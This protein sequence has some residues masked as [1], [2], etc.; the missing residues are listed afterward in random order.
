MRRSPHLCAHHTRPPPVGKGP[1]HTTPPNTHMCSPHGPH[2]LTHRAGITG[3]CSLGWQKQWVSS[4]CEPAPPGTLGDV[5][6][7]VVVMT[8]GVTASS[9]WGPWILLSAPQ[10]PGQPPQRMTCPSVTSAEGGTCW[11]DPRGRG[12]LSVFPPTARCP[13]RNHLSPCS[14]C[15]RV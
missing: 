5:W 1:A 9:G 2:L 13:Q 4:G 14:G 3:L 11:K 12:Q 15:V 7:F 6:G 10:C 8:G